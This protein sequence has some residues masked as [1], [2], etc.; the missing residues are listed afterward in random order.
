M[1]NQLEIL[2]IEIHISSCNY[3]PILILLLSFKYIP[4]LQNRLK[5]E[6]CVSFWGELI[7]F[8]AGP[9]WACIQF[10]TSIGALYESLEK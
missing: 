5:T 2:S 4:E 9:E 10:S 1:W 3:M 6:K 8:R 7:T